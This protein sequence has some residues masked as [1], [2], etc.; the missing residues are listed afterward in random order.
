M[1][2]RLTELTKWMRPGL[3]IKRWLVLLAFGMLLI[4]IGLAHLML[5]IQRWLPFSTDE[6]VLLF[7]LFIPLGLVI[8]LIAFRR[9][10]SALVAP[11]RKH[12]QGQLSDLMYAHNVRN[13]GTRVV[14]IGGGTGLPSV[15]RALKAHTRNITAVV[16]VADD[17]GSSGRLRRD[18]GVLPP[19]DLRNN[20]AALADDENLMTRL[21]QY[22][23]DDG[24]LGG[25]AFGNLFITAL[26][27]V[28]GSLEQALIETERVLNIQGSVFPATLENVGLAGLVRVE[29]QA[30]PILTH[31]ESRISE[32]GGRIERIMLEPPDVPAYAESVR[33][34][35]EADLIVIGPGSLYTSILPNLLVK[36][37]ATALR[38]TRASRIYVCN[39][40]TQPGET[41]GYTVADHVIA[42]EAHVGRGL[43]QI[44]LAND[45]YPVLNAGVNTHYVQP[46]PPHHE[47]F[48][49]YEV[50]Y[51]DLT[52]HE[53]PWRHDPAKLAHALLALGQ[54]ER[55]GSHITNPI[56]T[57][58]GKPAIM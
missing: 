10:L 53:R 14:A 48:Q 5:Y 7:A 28:T 47:I 31:G 36:D 26:T 56:F 1:S 42:L 34:I 35:L 29:G 22:R 9:L 54:E 12:Q 25:H 52:D 18:F 45:C 51:T 49:R 57:D 17:G 30:E 11:Y 23:F 4:A 38:A 41:D 24:D 6:S 33:A 16:T 21:F 13:K 3:R 27:G 44:V 55:I 40:A 46:A 15:L 8:S 50:R 39:V 2:G 37:I 20:I 58:S 19:G 32:M 43:F